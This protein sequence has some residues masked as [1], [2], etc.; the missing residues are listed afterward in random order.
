MD[1]DLAQIRAFV[2]AAE[3]LYFGR[4]AERL[5]LSPQGVSKRIRRL[6]QMLGEPLFHRQHNVVALTS[7]GRQFLPAA[8]RLLAMADETSGDLW[9][10]A[11][12]LRID[13]WGQ[14][15]APLRIINRLTVRIPHLIPE[16]S[17]RRSFAAALTALERDEVDVSF[18]RPY[19][20]PQSVPDG[21]VLQPT[22]LE[23]M[24]VAMSRSHANADLGVVTIDDLRT[25]GL[26]WPLENS[27]GEVAGFL[28]EFATHFRI[29]TSTEGLNLGHD[30]LLDVLRAN[31]DRLSLFG[32]EWPLT[33]ADGISLV[34]VRPVPRFL[35]WAACRKDAR[36]RQLRQ[37][38]G[39]LAET[40]RQE[41][42]LHLD[43]DVDWLPA[44]DQADLHAWAAA[45]APE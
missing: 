29:P 10:Q 39:M 37:F 2:V 40:S 17:M 19:D 32:R 28:R 11:R 34:A 30:H 31:P 27:Q 6:E 5:C 13:V 4:A 22:Y 36:H 24:A 12:P 16:L 23:P 42:W 41:G 15:H 7:T 14:V 43:P 38:M 21:L 8:R 35:W 1:F 44:A 18:G 26:W 25:T 3:E 33:A 45:E 20:L 9:P